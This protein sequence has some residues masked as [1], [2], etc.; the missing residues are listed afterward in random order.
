MEEASDEAES[1]R[2]GQK[3]S[4]NYHLSRHLRR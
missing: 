4:T 2:K 3:A 1:A